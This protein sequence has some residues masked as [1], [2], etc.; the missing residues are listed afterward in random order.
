[1]P[2]QCRGRFRR[3]RGD[4]WRL[5]GA[6]R[7][8]SRRICASC[9][10]SIAEN[11]FAKTN[12]GKAAEAAEVAVA[13]SEAALEKLRREDVPAWL[14][15]QHAGGRQPATLT[16]TLKSHQWAAKVG[17]MTIAVLLLWQGFAPKRLKAVPAP[18]IAIVVATAAAVVWS[19][20]VLYV[21]V[22]DSLL[23]AI[24][25]PSTHGAR[26]TIRSSGCSEPAS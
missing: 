13:Q 7:S 18:L 15:S 23:S 22:P 9:R 2:K 5:R 17:M 10:P 3:A 26:K 12:T 6:R 21:E 14:T 20:P 4:R 25:L 1:M 24:H 19:L 8:K 16:G 11:H